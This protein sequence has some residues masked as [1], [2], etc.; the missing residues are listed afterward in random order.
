MW[1][2]IAE[3]SLLLSF[4]WLFSVSLR[5]HTWIIIAIMAFNR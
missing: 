2:E 3:W 1:S 5:L 4:Y